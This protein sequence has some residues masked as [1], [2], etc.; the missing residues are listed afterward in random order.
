MYFS[1]TDNPSLLSSM[2]LKSFINNG[3]LGSTRC[4]IWYAYPEAS[5]PSFPSKK[6]KWTSSL[7]TSHEISCPLYLDI[8]E[9][10]LLL[11]AASS[12]SRDSELSQFGS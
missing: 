3:V 1:G 5:A 8:T 11:T 2:V 9:L 7:T 10:I 6:E 4:A 12:S